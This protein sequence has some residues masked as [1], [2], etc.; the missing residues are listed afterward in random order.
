[1]ALTGYGAR[2]I[3]DGTGGLG[4]ENGV[5][6]IDGDRLVA[7]YDLRLVVKGGAGVHRPPT[8]DRR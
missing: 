5:V 8:A 6:L 4:R 1:M 3:I 7:V 2:R